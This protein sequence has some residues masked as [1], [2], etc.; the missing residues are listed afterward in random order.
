MNAGAVGPGSTRI[1][2]TPMSQQ[3]NISDGELMVNEQLLL[4]KA[5]NAVIRLS[6]YGLSEFAASDLM[7]TVGMKG[8]EAIG[9]KLHVTNYRVIFKSHSFNRARGQF[10]IFLPTI[11]DIRDSSFFVSRKV[12]IGT[13]LAAFEFVVWGVRA[14]IEQVEA[15]RNALDPQTIELIQQAALKYAQQEE[16]DLKVFRGLENLNRLLL[17]SKKAFDVVDAAQNPLEAARMLALDEL[18]D[19]VVIERWQKNFD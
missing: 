1:L 3:M 5:A 9:G 4:S 19:R 13:K 16:N 10:S 12:T 18:F 15:A 17:E 8:K 7:W 6:E 14:V 11:R 2:K